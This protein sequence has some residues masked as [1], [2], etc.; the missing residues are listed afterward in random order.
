MKNI[1]GNKILGLLVMICLLSGCAQM[2]GKQTDISYSPE[3]VKREITTS[4]N[5]A[6][7][8]SSAQIID[9]L[10]ATQTDKTQ[11]FGTSVS[12][13]GATNTLATLQA[14]AQILEALRP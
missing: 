7:W 5:A 13:Q 14:L 1:M 8:F 9:K 6:T 10:K 11:S 2:R 3:G 12:Q 4:I